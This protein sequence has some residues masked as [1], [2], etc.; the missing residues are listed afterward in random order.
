MA[1]LRIGSRGSQLALWQS[2]HVADLLRSQGHTA[3]IEII[4]TTG[5]K[6]TDVA[7]S[8][9]G[10]KGMFTKEIEEALAAR[11]V[12]L[13][14]HSLKDLPTEL[15]GDF[16]LAAIMKREDPRDAFVS[17]NFFDLSELPDGA[18]VG[19]S[20]LRMR[21]VQSGE[22]DAIILAAAG[23]SR[24]AL[25]PDITCRIPPEIMC[26]AAGQG[27]L[28][29]EI[30]RGD[31]QTLALLS[32]LNDG[33]ARIATSCE[34]TLLQALGGGCQVPIGALGE[35]K[36]G[37]LVLDAMVGRPDGTEI[38][39]HHAEGRD[40][41]KLGRETAAA[42]IAKGADKIL[43]EIYGKDVTAIQQP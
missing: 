27:A 40:P 25:N 5:D 30:R 42:L 26:P 37:K 29:I 10:T 7:L 38:L 39:R 22:Y 21:K 41:E 24:L 12:D 6:I 9:V 36:G 19:T 33:E 20:S 28:G 23:V 8:M 18:R 35:L 14:V 13:A 11:S 32:F 17:S 16:E 15:Q 2:N 43:S 31:T 34:R 1:H 4:K 3:E